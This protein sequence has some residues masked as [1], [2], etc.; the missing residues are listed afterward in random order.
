MS[1]LPAT[2]KTTI[3]RGLARALGGVHLRIDTIEQAVV[4]AGIGT[5]PLGP[6]GYVVGYALA[7]DYLRQEL[8]V[9]ADSVN[10]LAITRDAWREVAERA[11]AEYVDVEVVC[12][13]RDEHRHRAQ[14]RVADIEGLRLPTWEAIE[15]RE[16]EPWDGYRLVVDTAGRELTECV[17]EVVAALTHAGNVVQR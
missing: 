1:G 10:P 2:W 11:G 12:L 9:V 3:A 5:R 4:R 17:A 16:Y 8:T 13:D 15:A 6:V 14:T 7:E